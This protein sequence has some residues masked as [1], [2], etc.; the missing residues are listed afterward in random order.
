MNSQFSQTQTPTRSSGRTAESGSDTGKD[1]KE[2]VRQAGDKIKTKTREVATQAREQGGKYFQL[3]KERAA[4]RIGRVGQSL[5]E[6]AD[7]FEEEEDP[8]IAH[9]TRLVA[10]KIESAAAY[11]RERDLDQLRRDAEELARRHPVL[12]YGG[13]FTLG[14]AAARFI[15]ASSDRSDSNERSDQSPEPVGAMG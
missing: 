15:K 4:N 11:V 8:N 6:T 14:L 9:Y 12:F 5:R 7:Q 3:N 10:G 2:A 13:L 1:I